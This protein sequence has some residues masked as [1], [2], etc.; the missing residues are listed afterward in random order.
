MLCKVAFY[1]LAL[2][3]FQVYK[4]YIID[5]QSFISGAD[6][7]LH[8]LSSQDVQKINALYTDY[9]TFL[10]WNDYHNQYNASDVPDYTTGFSGGV[11]GRY[12]FVYDSLS[13]VPDDTGALSTNTTQILTVVEDLS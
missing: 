11:H 10:N 12:T 3:S 7:N 4:E 8:Y 5:R 9:L 6:V 2:P 1:I 13:H